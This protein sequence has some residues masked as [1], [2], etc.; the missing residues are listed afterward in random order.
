MV[1]WNVRRWWAKREEIKKK[2]KGFDIVILTETKSRKDQNIK[3]PGYKILVKNKYNN[4]IGGAG[5]V[6]ILIKEKIK[7]EIRDDIY[8][9]DNDIDCAAIQIQYEKKRLI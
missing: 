1:V 8:V 3:I 6:A 7:A 4:N 5:G 9:D 2:V